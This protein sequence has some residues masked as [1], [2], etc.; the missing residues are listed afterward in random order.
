[1]ELRE[2]LALL[3]EGLLIVALPIVIAA[4][5]QHFRVMTRRLRTS[6]DEE[7]W[8]AIQ[9]SVVLG[10]AAARQIGLTDS[11]A[12]LR[13]RAVQLAQDF[14]DERGVQIDVNRLA[15]LVEAELAS[16]VRNPSLPV[17][18]AQA[19]QAL[20]QATIEAAVLAAEQSG[21]KG[22]IQN[23]AVDK[24]AYAMEMARRY[25]Q[26]HGVTVDESLIS[27]LI[28][29]QLLRLFLATRSELQP[30]PREPQG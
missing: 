15:M 9:R 21:M 11:L 2:F 17:D 28:E 12:G 13:Q 7:R 20:L 19:R 24:K 1:M 26:E 30:A 23:T 4:A 29:A 16:Q 3:A 10:V 27:G 25:L 8:E 14:L 22:L 5:I 6:G 18:T